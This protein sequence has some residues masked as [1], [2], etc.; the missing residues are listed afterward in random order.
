MLVKIDLKTKTVTR[1]KESHYMMI[2][3][4][5][6]QEEVAIVNTYAPNM[7]ASKYIKQILTDIKEE[8]DSSTVI[9]GSFHAPLTSIDTSS[10]QKSV[11]K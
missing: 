3:G 1:N 8:I 4:T 5:I 7:K 6:Q 11:W 9:V 10:R 2:K